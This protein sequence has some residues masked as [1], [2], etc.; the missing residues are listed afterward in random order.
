M[1][2]HHSFIYDSEP[3]SLPTTTAPNF[4]RMISTTTMCQNG[5]TKTRN[6]SL[7]MPFPCIFSIGTFLLCILFQFSQSKYP[8][9]SRRFHVHVHIMVMQCPTAIQTRCNSIEYMT[10]GKYMGSGCRIAFWWMD[11]LIGHT[12]DFL[13]TAIPVVVEVPSGDPRCTDSFCG[14]HAVIGIQGVLSCYRCTPPPLHRNNNAPPPLL[15]VG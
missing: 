7:A 1:L 9:C 2:D 10:G 3:T 14:Y 4:V 15:H 13:Q 11:L 12:I 8:I 6:K 5:S